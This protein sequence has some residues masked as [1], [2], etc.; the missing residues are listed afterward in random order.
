MC[1]QTL[2]VESKARNCEEPAPAPIAPLYKQLF[3]EPQVGYGA[4]HPTNAVGPLECCV[5]H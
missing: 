1:M 5:V 3:A 4:G 2:L